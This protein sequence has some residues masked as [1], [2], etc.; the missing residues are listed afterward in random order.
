MKGELEWMFEN[1]GQEIRAS[2]KYAIT[3]RE[4]VKDFNTQFLSLVIKKCHLEVTDYG[5]C[6]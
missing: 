5:K 6:V 2:E 1:S 3:D 4:L